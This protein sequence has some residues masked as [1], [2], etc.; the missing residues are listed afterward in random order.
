MKEITFR[1]LRRIKKT[2]KITVASYMQ[3]RKIKTADY[4]NFKL[5]INDEYKSFEKNELVYNHKGENL[6]WRNYNPEE[7]LLLNPYS[8]SDGET[9]FAN[10][11]EKLELPEK[12]KTYYDMYCAK[13]LDVDGVPTFSHGTIDEIYKS[14]L[15]MKDFTPLTVGVVNWWFGWFLYQLRNSELLFLED[16]N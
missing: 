12:G 2:G 11:R 5:I 1:P 3:W 9:L 16:I 15:D 13:G 8:L 6:F 4:S 10:Y 7:I 14:K